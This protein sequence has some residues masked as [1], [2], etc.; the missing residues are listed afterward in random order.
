MPVE[1][2]S[3]TETELTAL[4]GRASEEPLILRSEGGGD[5]AVL[6]LDDDV[7]DLLLERSPRLIEECRHIR[8]R[9]RRGAYLT[10]Q[11]MLEALAREEPK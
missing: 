6:P 3:P 1:K 10:H 4:L 7:L 11:Q 8:E 9:M 5:F 2:V